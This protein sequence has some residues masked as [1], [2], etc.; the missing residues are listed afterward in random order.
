ML[1]PYVA[2][3]QRPRFAVS[4]A[5]SFSGPR[6][7]HLDPEITFVVGENRSDRSPVLIGDSRSLAFLKLRFLH[8]AA[9]DRIAW[10]M[11]ALVLGRLPFY[12][13]RSHSG[14][15]E[16]FSFFRFFA[17]KIGCAFV[18]PEFLS[19]LIRR[20]DR[21]AQTFRENI[22]GHVRIESLELADPLRSPLNL[23]VMTHGFHYLEHLRARGDRFLRSAKNN[24]Q[25]RR[26]RRWI[27]FAQ[28]LF[29]CR[30]PEISVTDRARHFTLPHFHFD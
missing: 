15:G 19:A 12:E 28:S 27:E 29:I 24:S 1:L 3:Q 10:S 17:L 16:A 6:L 4:E 18:D 21:H 25:L 30:C 20:E 8:A 11:K 26:R 22:R 14:G 9:A 23:S 13:S 2:I 7:A 5:V